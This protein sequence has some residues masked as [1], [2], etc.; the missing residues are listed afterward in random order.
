MP[1]ICATISFSLSIRLMATKV[2]K[3][4]AWMR[5][6]MLS[7]AL[8]RYNVGEKLGKNVFVQA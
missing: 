5:T 7:G 8:I 4:N 6:K 1:I 3:I 2:G